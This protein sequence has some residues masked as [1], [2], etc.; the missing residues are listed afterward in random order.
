MKEDNKKEL[1]EVIKEGLKQAPLPSYKPGAWEAFHSRYSQQGSVRRMIPLW[2]TAAAVAVV[3]F[4]AVTVYRMGVQDIPEERQIGHEP[5]IVQREPKPMAQG[6]PFTDT[7]GD[8]VALGGVKTSRPVAPNNGHGMVGREKLLTEQVYQNIPEVPM[9]GI[10][11]TASLARPQPER[12]SQMYR[13]RLA[14]KEPVPELA[15][16]V[17]GDQ[18]ASAQSV[19][20]NLARRQDVGRDLRPRKLQI[21]D[22]LELGAFLS[23]STTNQSFDVGGGL[24]LAYKLSN[25]LAVRT[26]ASFNQYEVGILASELA[27]EG[28]GRMDSPVDGAQLISK[29]VPYRVNSIPLPNLNSVTGKIQ[30]LDI[31]VEFRYHLSKDFYATSGVSY[32]VVLSQERFNH[33]SGYSDVPT[34]SSASDSDSPTNKP[35][36]KVE[37][38]EPSAE[39][40]VHSNGFGGFVNFSIGRKTQLGKSMKISVEPFVKLPVGQFKRADMNYTNGGIKIITHF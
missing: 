4:A 11:I 24:V 19:D 9:A 15:T 38:T 32:A 8:D 37:R 18:L 34:Y 1:I 2:A 10:A 40:N 39:E 6:A 30:T 29:E 5:T 35:V 13:A 31:P 28:G 12:Q 3:A 17:L 23:P 21:A 20:P 22:R 26:G 33:Y 25:K 27:S 36:N 16:T 7:E 14:S